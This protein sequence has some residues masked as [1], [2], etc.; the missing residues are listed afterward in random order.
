MW[1][2]S[3][4]WK[5]NPSSIPE[6]WKTV[7]SEN[8]IIPEEDPSTSDFKYYRS[9]S[10]ISLDLDS[11]TRRSIIRRVVESSLPSWLSLATLIIRN[12]Y[13][14]RAIDVSSS[15]PIST[16]L[17]LSKDTELDVKLMSLLN[18]QEIE[19]KMI[20]ITVE[21]GV[22]IGFFSSNGILTLNVLEDIMK[23]WRYLIRTSLVNIFQHNLLPSE[24]S[25]IHDNLTITSNL[26]LSELL[27]ISH[28][29][30]PLA[31]QLV[32]LPTLKSRDIKYTLDV[33]PSASEAK[34]VLN[35][36]FE[37]KLL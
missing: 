33:G 3:M 30:T 19:I 31:S 26:L 8:I 28:I 32:V 5:N 14:R 18:K 6:E 35:A 16:R 37:N 22:S 12:R 15:Y 34:V 4:F 36:F 20:D 11:S 17:S 10:P 1:F 24:L 7:I 9:Q 29:Y 21:D 2:M 25:I 13:L 23:S 27:K